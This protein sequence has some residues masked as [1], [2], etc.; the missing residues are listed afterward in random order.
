VSGAGCAQ[1][2]NH[3]VLHWQSDNKN[4]VEKLFRLHNTHSLDF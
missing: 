1:E 3:Y 2:I 4:T